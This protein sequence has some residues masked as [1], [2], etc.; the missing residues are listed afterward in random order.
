MTA[1]N[2]IVAVGGLCLAVVGSA[3]SWAKE[4]PIVSEGTLKGQCSRSGGTFSPSSN[5]GAYACIGRRGTIK[6]CGGVTKQQKGS[7]TVSAAK[8]GTP[9]DRRPVGASTGNA[10]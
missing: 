4:V 5:G 7:C 9:D 6:T 3:P 2:L 10:R 8:V 1:K